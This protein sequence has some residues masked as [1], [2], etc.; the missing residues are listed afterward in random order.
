MRKLFTAWVA[1][2]VLG[3]FAAVPVRAL[4]NDDTLVIV[5]LQTR[6]TQLSAVE[7]ETIFTRAQTRW[8]D[9]TPIV[10]INAPTGTALRTLFDR[11]VLRL[12]PEEVGRFWIDRRIRGMG[13]P[14]RNLAEPAA[15]V[16]VVEKLNGAIAYAPE[17][18]VRGAQVRI[19]ARIHEGKVL[20]P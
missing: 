3:T 9:G 10:P 14:P 11:V 15:V 18:L 1:I 5:N 12:D 7:I 6:V 2:A 8:D 13:V 19:V 16:R 20:P 17:A 4:P